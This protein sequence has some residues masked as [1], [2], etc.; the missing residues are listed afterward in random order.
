MYTYDIY[1]I[2]I[3]IAYI[4]IIYIM[5]DI[6]IRMIY[7]YIYIH[8]IIKS[9]LCPPT[10]QH[11]WTIGAGARRLH[12]EA[13]KI[14]TSSATTRLPGRIFGQASRDLRLMVSLGKKTVW[15]KL[16]NM[17]NNSLITWDTLCNMDLYCFITIGIFYQLVINQ[18]LTHW[19]KN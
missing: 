8:K 19:F 5:Y 7:I 18:V 17:V 9:E 13:S 15:Y 16:Y 12:W 2:Y 14:S 4:Y 11:W 1:M 10:A 3:Y 6:Y